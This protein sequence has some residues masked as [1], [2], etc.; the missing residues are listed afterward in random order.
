[1]EFSR[2]TF[3]FAGAAAFGAGASGRAWAEDAPAAV[4]GVLVQ[5]SGP[6]SRVTLALDRPATARTMFLREPDRFVID[7]ANARLALPSNAAAS[8]GVVRA[9][10]C[11]QHEGYA[12]VV[13][14]LEAPASLVRQEMGR[15]SAELSF[16]LAPT[17]P[18][19]AAPA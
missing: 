14:D 17:A 11:A 9:V 2:R 16:D 6:S 12:R 13:L 10:R 15:R 19:T 4:R 8:G 7:L 1:M 18:F 3:L 5:A